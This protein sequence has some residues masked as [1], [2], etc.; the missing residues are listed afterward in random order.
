MVATPPEST[1][2]GTAL[3][4]QTYIHTYIHIHKYVCLYAYIHTNAYIPVMVATPPE[5]TASGAPVPDLIAAVTVPMYVCMYVCQY[6]GLC[7]RVNKQRQNA[8]TSMACMNIL[9]KRP[10]YAFIHS[11]YTCI[12]ACNISSHSSNTHT[13]IHACIT[14]SI[15]RHAIHIQQ[16]CRQNTH[17]FP[18]KSRQRLLSDAQMHNGRLFGPAPGY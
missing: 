6:D 10:V 1:A 11:T 17:N 13:Y 4:D 16:S 8:F 2:S 18:A 5:S 7:L 9:P 3:G 15:Y 12:H 14:C